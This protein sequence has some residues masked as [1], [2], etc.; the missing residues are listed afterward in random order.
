MKYFLPTLNQSAEYL[1]WY[2]SFTLLNKFISLIHLL[3]TGYNTVTDAD[4]LISG[5]T[6]ACV[7]LIDCCPTGRNALL[8]G[9]DIMGGFAHA[10]R[11]TIN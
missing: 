4:K 2:V 7:K 9:K 3:C 5:F 1:S 6:A 11:K 10:D 8:G